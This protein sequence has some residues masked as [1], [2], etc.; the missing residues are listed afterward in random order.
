MITWIKRIIARA[1]L[2]GG[3]SPP[4]V[5]ADQVQP[6]IMLHTDGSIEL[7]GIGTF[8]PTADITAKEAA[9]LSMFLA[10]AVVQPACANKLWSDV[11]ADPA[12]RRHFRSR[13]IVDV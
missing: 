9:Y 8:D 12:L 3:D 2:P 7:V 4:L 13:E 10:G 6:D 5:S 1:S 11:A